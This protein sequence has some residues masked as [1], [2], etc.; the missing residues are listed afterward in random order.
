MKATFE[1][2]V[3]VLVKAYLNETLQ[4]SNCYAC[5]VGNMIAEACGIQYSKEPH[6]KLGWKGFDNLYELWDKSTDDQPENWMNV[7]PG[8]GELRLYK[9]KGKVKE[10]IDSTGYTP[11]QLNE[12]E[13]AFEHAE[14]GDD[15][16]DFM[17]NG[18]MAVVD[19][20]AQI[21][22]VDLSTK[23]SAKLLFVKS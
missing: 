7:I 13:Y 1:N 22:N 10:M 18:L 2:S 11:Q 9:Y 3:S 14:E 8:N 20:L 21:H 4:H 12:I 15:S 5:A 23:E 16:D 6:K 19:V 17:F